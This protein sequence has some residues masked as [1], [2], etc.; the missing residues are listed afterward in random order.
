MQDEGDE[1]EGISPDW[2]EARTS[3]I[4]GMG[5]YA[6]KPIP[7]ETLV[8]EY[9]GERITKSESLRRCEEGNPFIFSLDEEFDLDGSI[10]ANLARFINH[11][12]T[13]NCEAEDH[14]GR[15]WIVARREI[16][17]GEELTYNYNYDLEDY[18]DNPCQCGA[19][20]CLGFMVAEDL[21]PVV[22]ERLRTAALAA[23]ETAPPTAAVG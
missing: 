7:A 10:E 22:R 18:P 16:A 12:C 15:I 23:V 2:V 11:S 9:L 3:G 17:V 14:E 1:V 5:L 13:P 6:M 19:P 20:D 4:H 21:F 8:I